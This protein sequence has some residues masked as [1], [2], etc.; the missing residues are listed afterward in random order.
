MAYAGKALGLPVFSL[1]AGLGVGGLA[2]ALAIR[3]TLENLVGG[4]ILYSDRTVRVGDLCKFKD[5]VGFVERIGVRSISVR[6]L[7]Q[8]LISVPNARFAEMEIISWAD[9]DKRLIA[10]TIGLRY[11][12]DPD[13]L[14]YI[15]AKTR[16]MFHAHPKI[17]KNTVRVRFAGYGASSLDIDIR[18]YALT[19]EWDEFYA[20]REDVLLRINDIVRNSGS[21]FA[22]PSRTLYV[23]QDDGLNEDKG[24]AAI[25]QV[26][27][28][29][30]SGKLPFPEMPSSSIDQLAGTVDYPPTG[31]FGSP[32]M[33]EPDRNSHT[34]KA[35]AKKNK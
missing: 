9:C 30:K 29:R 25:E 33:V 10:S 24:K 35:E 23:R 5:H 6:A 34:A 3:P 26:E 28:W 27:A 8:T 17:D 20:I 2:V 15:L 18:V 1:I 14:R 12:T 22:F 13:Q 11:E 19:R 21:G 7:D 32:E 4:M 31:S 16:E